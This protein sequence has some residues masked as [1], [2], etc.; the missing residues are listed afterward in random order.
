MAI[1]KVIS[2][3]NATPVPRSG[4]DW[5]DLLICPIKCIDTKRKANRFPNMCTLKRVMYLSGERFF[6]KAIVGTTKAT[7]NVPIQT[8]Q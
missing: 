3:Y 7:Y 1:S 4:Y 5:A 6:N 8:S 2:A